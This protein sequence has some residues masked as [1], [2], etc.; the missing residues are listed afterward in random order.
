ME[1]RPIYLDNGST[2]FPKAPGVG[3]AMA[4]LLEQAACNVG[5]GGY[6]MAYDLESAVLDCREKICRLFHFQPI[7][8]VIFTQNITMSLNL[9]VLGLLEPGD[10]VICSSMEHNAVARPLE[11]ARKRGVELSIAPCASD[12]SLDPAVLEPLFRPN[13]KAVILLHASNVCGTLLPLAE[14]GALCRRHGVFFIADTAQSA[15]SQPIDFEAMQLDGLAFTGH[16]GLLGP[17]GIGGFLLNER[18]AQ[19]LRPV[20]CGGTG[21]MSDSLEMPPFLPDRYESGT[22]NLPGIIGL[23]AALDYLEE[24]GTDAIR[25]HE[26]ELTGAFLEAVLNMSGVRV[27]GKQGTEGRAAIVSLDFPELDNGEVAF[28][29]ENEF[30]ILTRVGLHCAP[31][32]HQ[33]LGSFPSGSV[34]F[35]I[36]PFNTMEQIR[37]AADAVHSILKA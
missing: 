27:L 30:G 18:L 8:N 33:T 20:F 21:S 11:A 22:P 15:G 5:R 1:N 24:R 7:E 28:R 32:A 17:Q 6:R 16:K 19:A 12:G 4:K 29:L 23:S 10:H 2:S 36:G 31:L 34:R 9:L 3:A 14:V 37:A 25:A 26:S 35:G 13:T